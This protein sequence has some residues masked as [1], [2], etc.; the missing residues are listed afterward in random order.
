MSYQNSHYVTGTHKEI[1][2]KFLRKLFRNEF[3]TSRHFHSQCNHFICQ[4]IP[5]WNTQTFLRENNTHQRKNHLDMWVVFG[6]TSLTTSLIEK[7]LSTPEASFATFCWK[8]HHFFSGMPM[9]VHSVSRLFSGQ[10]RMVR[11]PGVGQVAVGS[12]VVEV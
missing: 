3:F 12:L 6:L 7:S 8:E 11:S 1:W 4:K 5:K 2:R 10:L 9:T